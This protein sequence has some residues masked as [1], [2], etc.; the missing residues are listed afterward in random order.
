MIHGYDIVTGCPVQISKR[1]ANHRRTQ[2]TH[3]KWL[4]DIRRGQI[5]NDPFPLTDSG[6]PIVML[7]SSREQLGR[8]LM[9]IKK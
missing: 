7:Q 3:T 9:R 5:N 2:V 4:G 8:P 6:V 1:I